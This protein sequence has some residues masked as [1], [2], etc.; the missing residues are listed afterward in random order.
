VVA[1]EALFYPSWCQICRAF[2]ERPTERA[3]C[4]SCREKLR[5]SPLSFCPA[6]GRFFEG[7]GEPHICLACLGTPPPFIRHRSCARYEG[8]VKD[9]ILL[10]KYHG[11]EILGRDLADFV[12]RSLDKADD[13][14]S[15]VDAVI[16]VP[17]HRRREKRRGF[18]QSAVLARRIAKLRNISFLPGRLI[19]VRNAPA[20]TSLEKA[21]REENVRDAYRV[22]RPARLRGITILLVD[23]VYTTGSTIRECSRVLIRAGVKEV[24]AVTV[25]Q[26]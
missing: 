5:P 16:P 2:L 26:A 13:L 4:Q 25:A 24:R 7:A 15:D 18:N 8:I 23:D 6:C 12:V 19:K 3:I 1:A 9:V 20:Q 17:L 11:W 21:E 22:R 10:F 14:W